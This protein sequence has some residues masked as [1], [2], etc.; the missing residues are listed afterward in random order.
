MNTETHLKKFYNRTKKVGDCLIWQG[1]KDHLGYG[2]KV[3]N[4]RTWFA[5]R[6]I[7]MMNGHDIENMHVC[8]K[9]D[10]PSCV[11]PDH[12]FVSGSGLIE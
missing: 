7:M 2:K 11:K 1:T 10:N 6:W 8:H 3:Y 4:K 9:C 12:L 5:H